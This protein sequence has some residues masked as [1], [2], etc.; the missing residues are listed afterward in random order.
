MPKYESSH[1]LEMRSRKA[2]QKHMAYHN[3]LPPPQQQQVS[4]V[5]GNG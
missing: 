4:L 3:P 1:E 5:C 2:A